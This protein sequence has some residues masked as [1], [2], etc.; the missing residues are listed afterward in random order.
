M[1]L[2]STLFLTLS[3]W[4]AQVHSVQGAA[5]P[6]ARTGGTPLQQCK[7]RADVVP[8]A[9]STRTDNANAA[10]QAETSTDVGQ[11]MNENGGNVADICNQ[12]GQNAQAANTS[13]GQ[14]S[15]Q[16]QAAYTACT[17]ACAQAES[18]RQQLT[19]AQKRQLDQSKRKCDS[20]TVAQQ[21]ISGERTSAQ[22]AQQR[23]QQCQKDSGMGQMPQMPQMPQQ[24]P[25]KKKTCQE[26]PNTPECFKLKEDC[27]NPEFAASNEVCKCLSGNCAKENAVLTEPDQGTDSS[28]GGLSSDAS[29]S[30]SL[31]G[32]GGGDQVYEGA[33]GAMNL[34]GQGGGGGAGVARG[35]SSDA[36]SE[37]FLGEDPKHVS[38]GAASGS[39][40]VLPAGAT[41]PA[42]G[43]YSPS[44]SWIPPKMNEGLDVEKFRPKPGDRSPADV[45]NRSQIHGSHVNMWKQINLR[46][47]SVRGSLKP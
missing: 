28:A 38:L 42:G 16:C 9:C 1:T 20:A 24:E 39:G 7:A 8:T 25:E 4:A 13:L 29:G 33:R 36:G 6:T 45:V 43:S 11:A 10:Q 26:D 14:I 23:A 18:S 35:S 32:G 12:S 22:Q 3:L 19:T 31:G 21:Q 47:L 44:G 17:S 2:H 27:A 34:Q 30:D 15:E 37:E 41:G 46:Y 5:P 40:L